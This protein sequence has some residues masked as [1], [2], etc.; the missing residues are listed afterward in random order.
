MSVTVLE[1]IVFEAVAYQLKKPV[2]RS[3]NQLIRYPACIEAGAALIEKHVQHWMLLNELSVAI[4][5]LHDGVTLD[6]LY[7]PL[8][9]TGAYPGIT[10]MQLYKWLTCIIS[11][12][13]LHAIAE[14][15]ELTQGQKDSYFFLQAVTVQVTQSILNNTPEYQAAEWNTFNNHSPLKPVSKAKAAKARK[16]RKYNDRYQHSFIAAVEITTYTKNNDKAAALNEFLRHPHISVRNT[17]I[18]TIAQVRLKA[19]FWK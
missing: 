18:M 1:P 6:D 9:F 13:D 19:A 5:N 10:E 3:H 2:S 17:A 14:E 11:N 15:R 8:K 7:I 12:I 4:G 16:N